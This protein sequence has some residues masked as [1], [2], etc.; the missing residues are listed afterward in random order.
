[1]RME[2]QFVDGLSVANVIPHSF[3]LFDVNDAY[4]AT[5]ASGG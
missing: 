2:L 4:D 1:M 3:V 5:I